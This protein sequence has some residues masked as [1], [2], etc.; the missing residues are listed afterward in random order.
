MSLCCEKINQPHQQH[1]QHTVLP[2]K[3]LLSII[4]AKMGFVDFVT[5]AGVTGMLNSPVEHI[6]KRMT[7]N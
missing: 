5:D 7:A 4:T 6:E 3:V 1:K 2:H